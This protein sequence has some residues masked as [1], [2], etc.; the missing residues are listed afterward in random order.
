MEIDSCC[1]W[2]RFSFIESIWV[3]VF[4]FQQ[5]DLKWWAVDFWKLKHVLMWLDIEINICCCWKGFSFIESIWV[6]SA[7]DLKE[8]SICVFG[9]WNELE[10][11]PCFDVFINLNQWLLLLKT[12][13]VH[14]SFFLAEIWKRWAFVFLEL[15]S[16]ETLNIMLWCCYKQSL[17]KTFQ[18]IWI[19]FLNFLERFW[20]WEK[21]KDLKK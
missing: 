17:L 19:F 21:L 7:A 14:L 18:F 15:K 9:N 10:I 20:K 3:F 16:V 8:M 11:E 4:F 13:F 12:F 2:K 6:F 5:A 1:C